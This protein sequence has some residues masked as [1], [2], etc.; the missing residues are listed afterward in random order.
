VLDVTI[1]ADV[2]GVEDDA[3]NASC[4]ESVGGGRDLRARSG[5]TRGD[6]DT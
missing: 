5:D 4:T 3:G 2:D 6:R 1:I